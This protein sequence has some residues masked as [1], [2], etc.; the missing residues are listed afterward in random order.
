VWL[1]GGAKGGPRVNEA[2]RAFAVR[3]IKGAQ[4]TVFFA[5][6]RGGD[7]RQRNLCRAHFNRAHDNDFFVARQHTTNYFSI[8]YKIRKNYQI[9]LKT[10]TN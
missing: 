6:R 2:G 8:I 1:G 5:V 9:K 10:S 3:W 4:Q 7:T